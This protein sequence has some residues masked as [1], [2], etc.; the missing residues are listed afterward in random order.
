MVYACSAIGRKNS[1]LSAFPC[2]WSDITRLYSRVAR[3]SGD[4][5]EIS[6]GGTGD[7]GRGPSPTPP[8]SPFPLP[9]EPPSRSAS[10]ITSAPTA[11]PATPHG[12][13]ARHPAA[14][15]PLTWAQH[16]SQNFA[17]DA[18]AAPHA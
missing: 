5:W 7:E 14:G 16:R 17:V 8:A 10:N 3:S 13:P 11:A 12:K 2:E 6:G 15:A 9:A 1:A 18:G 4:I